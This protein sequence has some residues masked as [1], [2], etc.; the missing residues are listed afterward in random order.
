M[1]KDKK[2]NNISNIW[3]IYGLVGVLIFIYSTNIVIKSKPEYIKNIWIIYII[4][5]TVLGFIGY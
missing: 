5:A 2:D 1:D 3:K 4:L